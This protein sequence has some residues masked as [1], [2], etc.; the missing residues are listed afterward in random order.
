M[1]DAALLKRITTNSEIFAGKPIIRGHRLAVEHVLRY[2]AAGQSND[3][4]QRP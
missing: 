1:E 2:F 4:L 3:E